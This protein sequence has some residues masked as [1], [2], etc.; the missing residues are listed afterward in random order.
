[1]GTADAVPGVLLYRLVTFWPPI[2]PGYL[3]YAY[4]RRVDRL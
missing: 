1:V 4:L 3:S 2:L